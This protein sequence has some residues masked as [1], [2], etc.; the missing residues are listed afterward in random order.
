[1][2]YVNPFRLRG[3]LTFNIAAGVFTANGN[4][5]LALRDGITKICVNRISLSATEVDSVTQKWS[6][7]DG[8]VYWQLRDVYV[9]GR[10]W[11]DI[12]SVNPAAAIA[13]DSAFDM[14]AC[15]NWTNHYELSN[16]V[17]QIRVVNRL[18]PRLNLI[19]H[20]PVA[21]ANILNVQA[22]VNIIGSYE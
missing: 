16:D 21:A 13:T 2:M 9:A 3:A 19:A 7:L 20:L 14:M 22:V 18:F 12:R 1:M 10:D 17:G 11:W 5:D 6:W 15:S 8:V 4:L